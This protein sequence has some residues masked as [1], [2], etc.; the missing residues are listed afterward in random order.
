MAYVI[1]TSAL[2][3]VAIIILRHRFELPSSLPAMDV[4]PNI[5]ERPCGAVLNSFVRPAGAPYDSFAMLNERR[6]AARAKARR[7]AQKQPHGT[8]TKKKAQEADHKKQVRYYTSMVGGLGCSS[9]LKKAAAQNLRVT[10]KKSKGC[11]RYEHILRMVSKMQKEYV[12]NMPGVWIPGETADT[13]MQDIEDVL[14]SGPCNADWLRGRQFSEGVYGMGAAVVREAASRRAH[15][16][17][18]PAPPPATGTERLEALRG[19]VRARH[20]AARE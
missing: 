9:L 17:A 8:N 11:V 3:S 15:A 1:P 10:G 13:M 12:K 2:Y 16:A 4:A 5:F 6:G 18:C 19:R 20:A 14:K 7:D